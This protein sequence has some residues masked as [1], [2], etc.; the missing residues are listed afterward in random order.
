MLMKGYV[1]ILSNK[2]NSVLYTGVTSNLKERIIQ[3]KVRKHSN[4]FSARYNTAKLVNYE[5]F[6]T[7]GEAIKR[8]KQIKVGSRKKKNDLINFKNPE[9]R[10]LSQS[11]AG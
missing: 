7:M 2:N 5:Q 10:D 9:W 8:E 6:E 11:M 3:H 4:S 1:Y